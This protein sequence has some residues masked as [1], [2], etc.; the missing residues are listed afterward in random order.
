M[1]YVYSRLMSK[2]AINDFTKVKDFLDDDPA[3]KTWIAYQ[4]G[5]KTT[6]AVGKWLIRKKLPHFRVKKI[7]HL[8]EIRGQ[9][10]LSRS[11]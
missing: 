8:I 10:E 4:L 5:Y 3:N 1:K 7:L 11:G 9:D 6:D 2:K